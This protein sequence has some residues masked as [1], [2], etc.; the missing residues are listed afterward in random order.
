M[1]ILKKHAPIFYL[2][3]I[4]VYRYQCT[5]VRELNVGRATIDTTGSRNSSYLLFTGGS[6]DFKICVPDPAGSCYYPSSSHFTGIF[7]LATALR[8]PPLDLLVVHSHRRAFNSSWHTNFL[9][10]AAGVHE[11]ERGLA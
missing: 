7:A 2:D 11:D 5:R 9:A 3:D 6:N 10:A 4:I 1:G 8:F